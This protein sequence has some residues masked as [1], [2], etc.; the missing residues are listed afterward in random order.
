MATMCA[1]RAHLHPI[2]MSGIDRTY[3][4]LK[5]LAFRGEQQR[6]VRNAG[7]EVRQRMDS[8]ESRTEQ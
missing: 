6:L 7:Y 8:A 3:N 2:L 4:F 5:T 1:H